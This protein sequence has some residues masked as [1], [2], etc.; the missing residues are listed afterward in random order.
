MRHAILVLIAAMALLLGWRVSSIGAAGR[1]LHEKEIAGRAMA[2][3]I[4]RA[5][6]AR[7]QSPPPGA[8]VAP[9]EY[10]SALVD[11]RRI[12]GLERAVVA[13]RDCWRAGAYLF[14]VRLLN[15]IGWPLAMP[16]AEPAKEPEFGQRFE[17]WAWPAE[18][19]DVA[20]GLFFASQGGYLLQ[21]ENGKFAGP[22]ARPD[23]GG[24]PLQKLNEM[25]GANDDW[26]MLKKVRE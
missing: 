8:R 4:L 7:Q 20:L 21:G 18:S 15:K 25:T 1:R 9:Y 13:D 26:I 24:S 2:E 11:E 23:N 14:H 19:A 16:P 6:L 10:L 17:L 5:E 12:D 3:K 22:Q